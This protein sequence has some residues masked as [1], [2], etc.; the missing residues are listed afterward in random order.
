M[1]VTQRRELTKLQTLIND[2]LILQ[3]RCV[4]SG[5]FFFFSVTPDTRRFLV[6][7]NWE[8]KSELD[9]D[10]A[11]QSDNTGDGMLNVGWLYK[12]TP[13]NHLLW[14]CCSCVQSTT[15][16]QTAK[17]LW[18]M[19]INAYPP[20]DPR[21]IQLSAKSNFHNPPLN[22]QTKSQLYIFVICGGGVYL[23]VC[24]TLEETFTQSD[25]SVWI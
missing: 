14:W 8:V 16:L 6:S 7:W 13:R 12:F 22:F 18:L 2:F 3:Y 5:L 10:D 17:A 15:P 23:F 1:P 25:K 21:P 24:L 19:L 4:S 20:H 11:M 9:S